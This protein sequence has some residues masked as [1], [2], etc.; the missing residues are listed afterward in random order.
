MGIV[1][2]TGN[3]VGYHFQDGGVSLLD[4]PFVDAILLFVKLVKYWTCWWMPSRVGLV[5][6]STSSKISIARRGKTEHTWLGCIIGTDGSDGFD[7]KHHINAASRAFC[8]M[9]SSLCDKSVSISQRL[10]H[11]DAMVAPLALFAGGHGKIYIQDLGK[12]DVKFRKLVSAILGLPGGL[13]WLA[14]WHD[15]LHD[16][17]HEWNARVWECTEQAGVKFWCRRC[18]GQH[19]RLASYIA[20]HPDNRWSKCVRHGRQD[21][22]QNLENHGKPTHTWDW[23]IQTYCRWQCLGKWSATAMQTDVW[24]THMFEPSLDFRRRTSDS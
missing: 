13:D 4:L 11:S 23:Q 5:G 2:M 18:L 8:A 10:A 12:L 15:I 3:G 22:K 20:N 21:D 1:Q 16:I 17:F 7:L 19:W 24:M 9:N 14:P 6:E